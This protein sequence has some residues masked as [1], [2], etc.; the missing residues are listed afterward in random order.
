MP[1]EDFYN[2]G[3]RPPASNEFRGGEG[4]GRFPSPFGDQNNRGGGENPQ[5]QFQREGGGGGEP[6]RGQFQREGGGGREWPPMELERDG[7][8]GGGRGLTPR[9]ERKEGGEGKGPQ[10]RPER[11]REG[12]LP[13]LEL[14]PSDGGRDSGGQWGNDGIVFF[15]QAPDSDKT[16]IHSL[17]V[18]NYLA[19]AGITG[20]LSE[21]GKHVWRL[22]E[23]PEVGAAKHLESGALSRTIS[24]AGTTLGAIEKSAIARLESKA[25]QG[26]T[27]LLETQL[28]SK[29]AIGAG[30]GMLIAGG[31]MLA[32][33]L[34]DNALGLDTSNTGTGRLLVDAVA[35]PSVLVSPL[36]TKEKLIVA[37]ALCIGARTVDYYTNPNKTSGTLDTLLDR[38][39]Q[40]AFNN[41]VQMEFS[42]IVIPNQVDAVALPAAALLLPGRYKAFGVAGAYMLGRGV[43][44]L[45]YHNYPDYKD[46]L[47]RPKQ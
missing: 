3:R 29:L 38:M 45:R 24:G 33:K 32:G 1:G 14:I 42:K 35:I 8:G 25:A 43:N 15:P 30:K 46:L 11:K 34:L 39:G 17:D 27:S 44:A 16:R 31:S 5:V 19:L 2:G 12:G 41:H 6:P 40:D 37:G 4:G 28:A 10:L 20:A 21:G 47:V 13:P 18:P 22:L 23:M 36:P 7:G 9:P 26:A